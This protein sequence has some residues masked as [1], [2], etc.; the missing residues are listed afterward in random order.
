MTPIDRRDLFRSSAAAIA[1][2]GLG[3]G[4]AD[5]SSRT[6]A[7]EE[8]ASEPY[9]K[10][11]V[12]LFQ[13]DSITDSHRDRSQQQANQAKS[14]GDGYPFM[15]ASELLRDYPEKQLTIYNR[16]ISGHR[17]PNLQARWQTDCLDLKPSI[18]SVLVGVNDIWHKL[19]GRYDGT[20]EDY[21]SGLT[22]LLQQTQEALPQVR[23][24]L[25]EPFVLRCGA[26]TDDWFPEFT[27]RLEVARSVGEELSLTRVPF[28]EMFDEAV[29]EAPPKYWAADGVHP[30]L[31][32]HSL[33]TKT[34][35]EVVEEVPSGV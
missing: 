29:K 21:R 20:V 23:I 8:T 25:C 19:N 18:L 15:I 4:L 26:V 7:S 11:G 12:I 13:G 22:T 2:F 30:T 34:W 9:T 28:Q 10:N 17:V 5:R 1:A 16:G 6:R 14:L 35:R 3:S 27:E 32:G 24:I 31:A 33:M